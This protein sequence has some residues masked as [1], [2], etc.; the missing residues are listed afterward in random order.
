MKSSRREGNRKRM[1]KGRR[2]RG[3]KEGEKRRKGEKK[4]WK[5]SAYASETSTH[6]RFL[7]EFNFHPTF[8]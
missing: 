7:V 1:K 4:E 6:S 3:E 8:S 2:G 5:G